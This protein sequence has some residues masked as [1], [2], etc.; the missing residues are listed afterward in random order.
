MVSWLLLEWERGGDGLQ[1]KKYILKHC[2][3]ILKLH[4]TLRKLISGHI[5][6][7]DQ[8]GILPESY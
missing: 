1:F 5:G 3:R 6:I 4:K 2:I 7:N 8:P